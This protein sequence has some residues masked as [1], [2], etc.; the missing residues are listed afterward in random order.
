MKHEIKS[1][2]NIEVKIGELTINSLVNKEYFPVEFKNE[3]LASDI[4]IYPHENFREGY[5]ILFPENTQ[6]VYDYIK[7]KGS[8]IE[9]CYPDVALP[10]IELHNNTI[11]IPLIIC[12]S[13]V[14]PFLVNLLSGYILN[15][16]A[17]KN[18]KLSTKIEM[19]IDKGE[20]GGSIHVKFEGKVDDFERTV[21]PVILK[22]SEEG[23]L[24]SNKE[25]S[26]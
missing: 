21:L 25:I 1:E 8:K 16:Q 2:S 24:S 20:G 26:E 15:E 18:E 6:Q 13:L 19:T 10:R 4:I 7:S 17:K 22:E 11:N 23:G 14:A 5:K 9:V 3:I 12:T